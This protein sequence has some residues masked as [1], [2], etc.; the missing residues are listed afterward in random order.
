[1][2]PNNDCKDTLEILMKCRCQ[3]CPQYQHLDKKM[4]LIEP[5]KGGG[6]GR[7]GG[8]PSLGGYRGLILDLNDDCEDMK[9]RC[10]K[11]PQNQHL[12]QKWG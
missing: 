7:G 4:E 6:G 5:S 10:Q 9:C 2:D 11:C 1:M 12:D 8:R 3:K